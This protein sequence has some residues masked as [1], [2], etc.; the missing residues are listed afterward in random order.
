MVDEVKA[1]RQTA[2]A[3]PE[4]LI[5]DAVQKML[6]APHGW[7]RFNNAPLEKREAAPVHLR[8]D[9]IQAF[10]PLGPHME[11][12]IEGG[13]AWVVTEN[14]LAFGRLISALDRVRTY[15]ENNTSDGELLSRFTSEFHGRLPALHSLQAAQIRALCRGLR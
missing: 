7:L 8:F 6:D 12:R 1:F 9:Q 5:A 3:H 11:I 10:I 2:P 13:A 4:Q 15:I 14:Y